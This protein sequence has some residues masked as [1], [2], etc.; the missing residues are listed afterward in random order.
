MDFKLTK[1][2]KSRIG[3][4]DFNHLIFGK[5]FADHMLVADYENGEWQTPSI[6]PFQHLSLSPSNAALHYGQAIF[7]GIKAYQ[8]SQGNPLVFRP[9]E[10][11][12]RFNISAQRM[13]M[14]AVAE[15]LFMGGL[16]KLLDLDRAWI[17]TAPGCSLYIRPFM[18]A[19]DEFIGVKTS[20]RYK[21]MI[22]NSP[23]GAYYNKPLK[24]YIQQKYIRAFPGGTGFAKNAG[25]Y[26]ACMLPT[27]EVKKMGYDQILWT[28]G[29]D[30]QYLQE[31][32]TMNLF[33]MIGN[34][35]L[36]PDLEQGTILAGVTR[37][38]VIALLQDLGYVV[39]ER[40]ISIN[41]LIKAHEEGQLME[42]FGTG[43]AASI[44]FV[45][46]MSYQDQTIRL[47]P[48]EWKVS[49]AILETLHAIRTGKQ[50]DTRGW[51][52]KV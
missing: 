3:E 50:A 44:T 32:G 11:F 23:A 27:Q 8:D 28:G 30:Q 31:C 36:T 13:A 35:F 37:S 24:L 14:P 20:D 25:N 7:E 12:K 9:I 48:G 43:T 10:N 1:V 5:N 38:S 41:E 29:E 4:V 52:M 17:P 51:V 15:D 42:V 19:S 21:F 34:K 6:I 39:E 26:G 16:K 47:N 33:V 22:I 40:P 49:P 45:D 18:I 2:T 46:E